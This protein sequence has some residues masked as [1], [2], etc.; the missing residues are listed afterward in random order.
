MM[1]HPLLAG[2]LVAATCT[3]ASLGGFITVADAENA[4]QWF[5]SAGD[6]TT[7]PFTGLPAYTPVHEQYASLGVHFLGSDTAFIR[8]QSWYVHDGCGVGTIFSFDIRFDTPMR[9]LSAFHFLAAQWRFY[10]GTTLVYS[11]EE[12]SQSIWTPN[13]FSGFLADIAFDRVWIAGQSPYPPGD[14]LGLDNLYFSTIPAP[15]TAIVALAGMAL[16]FGR[17]ARRA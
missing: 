5:G 17:R 11:S 12:L 16:G 2:V 1:H 14:N 10:S 9:A 15:A 7:I 3:A 6:Y 13:R 4:G 8:H